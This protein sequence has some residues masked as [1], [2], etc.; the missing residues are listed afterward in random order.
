MI[1][2]V[3]PVYNAAAV[4]EK[5]VRSVLEQDYPNWELILVD[6]GSKDDSGRL[7]DEW[8]V[9]DVRIRVVHTPNRGVTAARALGAEEAIGEWV[10][11]VDADDELAEGALEHMARAGE[12]CD[13][14]VGNKQIVTTTT[15]TDE[16]MNKKDETIPPLEFL[17]GLIINRISQY[18]TGRMFRKKLFANGTIDIPADLIMAEDFIMN[19]QLGNKAQ[20]VALIR[21]MV[22]RYYVYD[23]SVSHTFRSSLAYEEKF[24]ACLET[25]VKQGDYYEQLWEELAFQKVR[26]LKMGFMSE[27]GRV[28]LSNHFLKETRKEAKSIRLTRGWRLFLTLIPLKGIGYEI[29]RKMD[30][31]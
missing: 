15:A 24:C 5:S 22:Y 1:S 8:A 13:I 20:K 3:I 2:I 31:R 6:D 11:F 23:S 29:M 28:D 7:C 30:K 12:G 27:K 4:L 19:V 10:C 26:A 14:V 17:K 25:A 16:W 9:Q 21:D 18:I